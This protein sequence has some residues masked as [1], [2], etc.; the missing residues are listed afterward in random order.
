MKRARLPH[1]PLLLLC[2]AA[3]SFGLELGSSVEVSNMNFQADRAAADTSFLPHYFPIGYKVFGEQQIDESLRL[4]FG[5]ASDRILRNLVYSEFAYSGSFYSVSVGPFLGV[6][7]TAQT[8]VK[9]GIIASVRLEM[10]GIIFA[11]V[12][13]NRS[14]NL[15]GFLSSSGVA[16][17]LDTVG[18]FQQE[19]SELG[20]GFYQPNAI[21]TFFIASKTYSEKKTGSIDSDQQTDYGFSAEIFQKNVPFKALLSFF[22]RNLARNYELPAASV[23]HSLGSLILGI[24]GEL[25]LSEAWSALAGLESSIYTFG[26]DKL[27]GEFSSSTYLFSSFLG[28]KARLDG[29]FQSE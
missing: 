7:N 22:Y 10:P 17:R 24:R 9:A 28:V 6:M 19:S 14:I 18:D 13:S 26:L 2:L 25:A 11:F 3:P 16:G 21:L 29:F 12:K 1:L 15:F 8:P 23:K 27:I 5:L 20:F 4:S